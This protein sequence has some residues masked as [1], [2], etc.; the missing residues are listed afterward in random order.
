MADKSNV[1]I[2]HT[3]VELKK[4]STKC[5]RREMTQTK[6]Q[7]RRLKTDSKHTKIQKNRSIHL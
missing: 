6:G 3:S 4:K 5:N 7:C 2:D 1:K